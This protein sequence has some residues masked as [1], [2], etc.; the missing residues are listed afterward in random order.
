MSVFFSGRISR[1]NFFINWL[2]YIILLII[3]EI[4]LYM[5]I[6]QNRSLQVPFAIISVI[7][8]LIGVVYLI[9]LYI[10]RLH[11][12]NLSGWLTLLMLVPLINLGL[13]IFL[14]F[15]RGSISNNNYGT[16]PVGNHFP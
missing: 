15:K 14:F 8:Y 6:T 13:L 12:M 7:V 4:V 5:V 1:L 2:A 11:D 10:R 3:L 16:P 9:S